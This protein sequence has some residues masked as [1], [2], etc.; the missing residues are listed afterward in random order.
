MKPHPKHPATTNHRMSR[1]CPGASRAQI[2]PAGGRSGRA[3]HGWRAAAAARRVLVALLAGATLA[4]GP[5]AAQAKPAIACGSIHVVEAGDTLF[6]IA[7][8]AYGDGERYTSI[9][10]ANNDLLPNSASIE[11]GD[12]ILVPCLD[13]SSPATRREA[14]ARGLLVE[15]GDRTATASAPIEASA[16]FAKARG[17]PSRLLQATAQVVRTI[18]APGPALTSS[19]GSATA[20]NG[21]AGHAGSAVA[22]ASPGPAHPGAPLRLV[23]GSGLPPYSDENLPNGGMVAEL[24]R[25]SLS[26]SA[27][28]RDV[29]IGFVNDW[30]SHLHVLLRDGGFDASF[31]WYRPDCSRLDRL[32]AEA[33]MLCTEFEFSNALVE[34]PFGY[35]ARVGAPALAASDLAAL[36]GQRLC[37]PEGPF[38]FELDSD[39]LTARGAFLVIAASARDCL[40]RLVRS[41]TDVVILPKLEALDQIGRLGLVGAVAEIEPLGS[42]ATLHAVAARSSAAKAD[43]IALLNRGLAELMR[44]GGWFEIVALHRGRH[45]RSA[46]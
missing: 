37:R 5:T 34:V 21:T 46:N 40:Y 42:T 26:E 9:H 36:G 8:R 23:T 39:R 2:G 41:E 33:R 16:L 24:V 38:P 19:L 25:R 29:R 28:G 45:P 32:A 4:A 20:P 6:E 12:R 1:R 43:S 15:T 3:G 14:I 11:I 7:E 13:G 10:A 22:P 30:P 35:Y 18:G 44:S 31:P 27:P 17:R